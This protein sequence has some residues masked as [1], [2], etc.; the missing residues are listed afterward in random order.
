M[1]K[2]NCGNCNYCERE[3]VDLICVNGESECV[4]DYVEKEHS[5]D[6]WEGKE[7]K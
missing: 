5:C 3:G 7:E 4:A 2:Q 6:D 1:A